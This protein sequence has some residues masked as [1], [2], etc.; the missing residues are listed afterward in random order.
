MRRERQRK[1]F[2]TE[3]LRRLGFGQVR[4]K[5]FCGLIN[6]IYFPFFLSLGY[7]QWLARNYQQRAEFHKE[8]KRDH[9]TLRHSNTTE[10]Q[11]EAHTVTEPKSKKGPQAQ[12]VPAF[13]LQ[14][15]GLHPTPRPRRSCSHA[16]H[17]CHVPGGCPVSRRR[18]KDTRDS[19]F[20]SGPTTQGFPGALWLSRKGLTDHFYSA[21]CLAS[22]C[23]SL[24]QPSPGPK[25]LRG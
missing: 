25:I 18:V 1:S 24:S 14:T 6:W 19:A 8:L 13:T 15:R 5:R 17:S 12:R 10:L 4:E 9:F 22:P 20:P 11:L 2:H 23:P 21:V 7:G 3:S 16:P